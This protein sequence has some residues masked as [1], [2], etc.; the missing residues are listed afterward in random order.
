LPCPNNPS[1]C[2]K[3]LALISSDVMKREERE[4]K[5]EDMTAR[6]TANVK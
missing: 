2:S 3:P 1:L 4:E 6:I 5:I